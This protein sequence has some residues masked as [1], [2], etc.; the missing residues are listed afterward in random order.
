MSAERTDEIL[1][2]LL[3]H[4]KRVRAHRRTWRIDIPA[5]LLSAVYAAGGQTRAE[6]LAS[7]EGRTVTESARIRAAELGK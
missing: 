7:P 4:G 5:D 3:R 2:L 6:W 1:L